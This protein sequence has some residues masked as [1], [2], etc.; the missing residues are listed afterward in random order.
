MDERIDAIQKEAIALK[1]VLKMCLQHIGQI[2]DQIA[3][4]NTGEIFNEEPE[5]PSGPLD[6]SEKIVSE[7]KLPEPAG[8]LIATAGKYY[9]TPIES[10]A[11][12]NPKGLKDWIKKTWKL[13]DDK[14][15]EYIKQ[16]LKDGRL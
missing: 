5:L 1:V 9:G 10:L 3:F 14:D 8:Y 13:I 2:I 4:Y 7:T 16:M 6:S 11:K 12:V 15:R